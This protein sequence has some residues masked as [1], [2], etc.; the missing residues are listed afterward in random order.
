MQAA[1][2][3]PVIAGGQHGKSIIAK[4]DG[5]DTREQAA[6]L[7]GQEIFIERAELPELPENQYYWVD[8]VGLQ[9]FTMEG[10]SLGVVDSLLET[11][12]HDVLVVGGERERLIPFVPDTFVKSVDMAKGRILVAWD[13]DF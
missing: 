10:D 12:A 13:P 2:R 9:V 11:G 7:V 8:L 1:V 3:Y 4:L 5:I 6:G